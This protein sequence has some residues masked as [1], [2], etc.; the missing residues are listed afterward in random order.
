MG[1]PS[2]ASSSICVSAGMV[3]PSRS[4]GSTT[5]KPRAMDSHTRPRVSVTTLR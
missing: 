3:R 5:D 4:A 1:A 2:A